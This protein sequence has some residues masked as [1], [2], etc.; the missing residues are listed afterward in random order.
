VRAKQSRSSAKPGAASAAPAVDDLMCEFMGVA[1]SIRRFMEQRFVENQFPP[2]L[3]GPR[4]GVLFHVQK[5]G[6]LRMGDLAER[7]GVNPRSVTDL[8]DGLARKGLLLRRPDPADRRATLLDLTPRARTDFERAHA[9]SRSFLAEAFSP[10]S[11][12]ERKQFLRLLCKM[13]KGP[14]GEAP[15]GLGSDPCRSPD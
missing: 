12:A 8:V 9:A 3:S 14:I 5:N 2:S 6:G 11:A 4:M 13:R 7:L 15:A 10:L 1:K